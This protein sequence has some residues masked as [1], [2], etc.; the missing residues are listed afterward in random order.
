MRQ[1]CAGLLVAAL[2]VPCLAAIGETIRIPRTTSIFW[3]YIDNNLDN[4]SCS[5]GGL[6]IVFSTSSALI[7]DEPTNDFD[8]FY[9][10]TALQIAKIV[11]ERPNGANTSA[12]DGWIS[13]DG[14]FVAFVAGTTDLV[15]G[16]PSTP[17]VYVYDVFAGTHSVASLNTA[18]QPL[19]STSANPHIN[20]NGQFVVFD[21]AATN[22]V[23]GDTNGTTDVFIRD[24]AANTTQ[25][26]SIAGA[27]QGNGASTN[28][29]VSAFGRF[30]AFESVATNLVP[31]DTNGKRDVF[32][33]DM[34]TGAIARV[35][36]RASGA[37]SQS[38][39]FLKGFSDDGT[40]VLFTSADPI[41]PNVVGTSTKLWYLNVTTGVYQGVPLNVNGL[42]G[43]I[44]EVQPPRLSRDGIYVSF[45]STDDKLVPNDTVMVDA[46]VRNMVAGG[47]QKV[48]VRSSGDPG[49]SAS[50]AQA[51]SD[52]GLYTF[53]ESLDREMT[54]LTTL[55]NSTENYVRGLGLTRLAIR[56]LETNANGATNSLSISGTG[57]Y[58]VFAS[59][60]SNLVLG[61]TNL[62]RDIF[63]WDRTNDDITLLS[64]TAGG[65]LGD[66]FSQFPIISRD[67][68]TVAFR[69]RAQNLV[70]G[71]F[72]NDCI[73]RKDVA[74]GALSVVSK[75]PSG[76]PASGTNADVS[77]D[78]RYISF[79]SSQEVQGGSTDSLIDV[80][81]YDSTTSSN[82]LVSTD[83]NLAGA[84]GAAESPVM[85]NDGEWIAYL[86]SS[87]RLVNGDTNGIRD[88]F[89]YNR[90]LGTNSRLL[91]PDGGQ[92][93]LAATNVE[94]S[95]DGRFLFIETTES[96]LPEDVWTGSDIYRYRISDGRWDMVRRN[97]T[98]T[99]G[100]IILHHCDGTGRY[101]LLETNVDRLDGN[102]YGAAQYYV[103]DMNQG[104]FN[105]VSKSTAG[106]AAIS[107]SQT[108]DPEISNNGEFVAFVSSTSNLS[109]ER[110]AGPAPF[111]HEFGP[112][113]ATVLSG[114]VAWNDYTG[115]RPLPDFVL[116][117]EDPSGDV[118]LTVS[119][120]TTGTGN[121]SVTVEGTG[122][123]QV[124]AKGDGY[125]RRSVGTITL[126]S[127]Q[128]G[129]AVSLLNGDV[130]GDNAVTIFDYIELSGSFDLVLGDPGFVPAAD[131][132]RD[133]GVTIFDYII[134]SNN[135]DIEGD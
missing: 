36:N 66:N 5:A 43:G 37:Q 9:Y 93:T 27:T 46:F 63:L 73:V 11:N 114:T 110:N 106:M 59:E 129:F 92:F 104:Q 116:E 122:T 82:I 75:F 119:D 26:V 65:V 48:S 123:Y 131:L 18:G 35:S 10:D 21:S 94:I 101:V 61:D 130:D 54:N 86:S 14:G 64:Q 1:F 74:T 100:G 4:F 28:A 67:G 51:V 40:R 62:Q 133:G 115:P 13:G 53:F 25:R 29:M 52:G 90:P 95:G 56:A 127:N 69:T 33:R 76:V 117:F 109:P 120:G 125:L 41:L 98:S 89:L 80:Y 112:R 103:Y 135:F 79:A 3:P 2:T 47:I 17:S 77:A 16:H 15:A 45:S 7:L 38:D 108:V 71:S 83:V 78:G 134:L 55:E 44:S 72:S 31:G 102:T 124:F 68:S 32:V 111:S 19:T 107:V 42:L 60:M 96:L 50:Y 85:S 12:T 20:S 126:G 87:A 57:R 70:G 6:R 84:N 58:V 91:K 118:I 121:W 132:D 23:P 97:P 105:L 8:I 49:T 113:G 99:V 34:V 39:S 81:L 128:S 30:V 88:V 22:A 24:R